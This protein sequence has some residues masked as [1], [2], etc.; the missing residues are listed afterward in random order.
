MLKNYIKIAW[1]NLKKKPLFSFINVVGL[2]TGLG[3]TFFFYLWVSDE[4]M[5]DRFHKNDARLYQIMEKSTENGNVLIH[6][7]TQGPL[8]E[9]LEKDFP[10]V[11]HAVTVMN[12]EKEGMKITFTNE[13]HAYKSAGVFSSSTF[14]D[15]FTFPLIEGNRAQVLQEKNNIVV[16]EQL[17]NKL[18]GSSQNAMDKSLEYSIF[19]VNH[20]AKISGVCE[21]VPAN[22]TLKFD[23]I[24][25]KTKL[26]EDIWVNGKEWYNTGPET[27][28]LLKPNTNAALF[29]GKISNLIDKYDEGNIFSIF[30]RKFSDGYLY[31]NYENGIQSGGRITYVRLFSLIA[32][33]VLLIACINFI[34]LS[35]AQ[36]SSRFKEIGIKKVVGTSRSA[37]MLQFLTESIVLSFLAT[38]LAI[39][40]VL[41]FMPSFNYIT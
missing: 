23:F 12:L 31:G 38:V 37:L 4:L 20:V 6:D 19:G 39:G 30:L 32:I 18:F 2:T 27:Y 22:S 16:S 1:R 11:E 21:D 35:T 33:L 26:L 40:L 8:A 24:L 41:L 7:H 15:I 34:N 14:F 29:E 17:A 13:E 5:I 25:S 10:E 28:V 9:A 3:C 36:V